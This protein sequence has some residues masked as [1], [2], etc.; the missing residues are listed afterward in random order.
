MY[1]LR[2]CRGGLRGLGV[3]DYNDLIAQANLQDCSPTDSAC[4]SNNAAKQAAVEDFWAANQGGVPD[5][6]KLTFTAQTP[7]EVAQFYSGNPLVGGN[8]V[9]DA[10]VL[11][12]NGT[13]VLETTG[14]PYPVVTTPPKPVTI[15]PPP[16]SVSAGILPASAAAPGA[17]VQGA[18]VLS[19]TLT[20]PD[21]SAGFDFSA[22]PWYVWAGGAALAFFALKGGK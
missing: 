13:P 19:S 20:V 15:A 12:V 4:V 18:P 1:G 16:K 6:T 5:N 17:P 10:G 8:V 2:G 21:F 22:V 11:S 7:G 14:T 3:L 9:N